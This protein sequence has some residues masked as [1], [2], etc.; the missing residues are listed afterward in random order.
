M[1]GEFDQFEASAHPSR[2]VLVELSDQLG[3]SQGASAVGEPGATSELPHCHPRDEEQCRGFQKRIRWIGGV[4][5]LSWVCRREPEQWSECG[6][7]EASEVDAR[8]WELVR[9][10]GSRGHG[11]P[12]IP[13]P[14]LVTWNHKRKQY[15]QIRKGIPTKNEC[16]ES[17][18]LLL[19]WRFN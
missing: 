11:T 1:E 4:C 5:S 12:I 19:L 3:V 18:V 14:N 8:C 7:E 16:I 15:M 2:W 10:Q 17:S 13:D 9:G 6:G